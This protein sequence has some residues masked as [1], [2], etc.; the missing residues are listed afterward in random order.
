MKHGLI[1]AVALAASSRNETAEGSSY[2]GVEI[3]IDFSPLPVV[4][5]R[6]QDVVRIKSAPRDLALRTHAKLRKPPKPGFLRGVM[7]S[8]YTAAPRGR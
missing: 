8:R 1:F 3:V 5:L 4:E 7:P 2:G 6:P